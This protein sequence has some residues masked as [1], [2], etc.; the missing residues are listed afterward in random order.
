MY[1][2]LA[3]PTSSW[4]FLWL[5]LEWKVLWT[6]LLPLLLSS[7]FLQVFQFSTPPSSIHQLAL[8]IL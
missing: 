3:R 5:K 2:I 6:L 4:N 1:V 7:L 8:S